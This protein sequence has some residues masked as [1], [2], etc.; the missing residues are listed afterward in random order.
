MNTPRFALGWM[1]PV[2]SDGR[3]GKPGARGDYPDVSAYRLTVPEAATPISL[4]VWCDEPEA[5][6]RLNLDDDRVLWGAPATQFLC[7]APLEAVRNIG[8]PEPGRLLRLSPADVGHLAACDWPRLQHGSIAL[9]TLSH[10]AIAIAL[11]ARLPPLAEDR[12]LSLGA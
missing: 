12:A 5:V 11:V 6:L 2:R 9:C 10:R 7:R 4:L 3:T 1:T 8:R